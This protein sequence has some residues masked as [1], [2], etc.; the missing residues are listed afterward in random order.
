MLSHLTIFNR[1]T[2]AF[3]LD[4]SIGTQL[5]AVTSGA[6]IGLVVIASFQALAGRALYPAQVE[7][8]LIDLYAY[9]ESLVRNAIQYAAMQCLLAFSAYAM[10]DYLGQLVGVTRLQ[11]VGASCALQFTVGAAQTLPFVIP[12]ATLV[13]TQDVVFSFATLG[14]LTIPAGNVTGVINAVCTTPGPSANNYAIG[15]LTVQ[16]NPNTLISAVY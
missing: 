12:S 2:G 9:R 10:L 13:G 4:S 14:D 6:E 15:Q 3:A 16:L 11:A 1:Q 7:R 5:Q 8:L